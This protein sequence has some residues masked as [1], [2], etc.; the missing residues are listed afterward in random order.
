M[1]YLSVSDIHLM[2]VEFLSNMRYSLLTSKADWEAWLAKLGSFYDYYDAAL[3]LPSPAPTK[4]TMPS[5]TA[6]LYSS[7]A[8]SPTHMNGMVP[9]TTP[10]V[11]YS[12]NGMPTTNGQTWLPPSSPLASRPNVPMTRK[13]SFESELAEPPAKR[14]PRGS[15]TMGSGMPRQSVPVSAPMQPQ[16][17]SM[18]RMG[19]VP[20]LTLDTAPNAVPSGQVMPFTPTNGV[21]ANPQAMSLPP[22]VPGV[23]AM[24]T[25][26]TQPPPNG[27]PPVTVPQ[28]P[29]PTPV[30]TGA[31]QQHPQ[32]QSLQPQPQ[33]QP[34][35]YP[36]PNKCQGVYGSSPLAEAYGAGSVAHTPVLH[37]PLSHSPSVYLQQRPSPYKPVRHVNTLLYPPPSAS[38]EEYHLA[39][40]PQ[41]M[42]YRPLGRRDDLRTG[43]VPEFSAPF[44]YGG[45]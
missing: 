21:P 1:S 14:M 19:Q 12:P 37:T 20:T 35:G 11:A 17:E 3:R 39:V 33:A 44:R 25:V 43:I 32:V 29:A 8:P 26:Y 5:P 24:Q 4:L 28:L 23:R 13:R 40:P 31:V 36:T 41:Q 38:L 2:E 15:Y 9:L 27:V 34:M 10:T 45:Y 7:P 22:L 42:H 6:G 16:V 30:Y 18:R